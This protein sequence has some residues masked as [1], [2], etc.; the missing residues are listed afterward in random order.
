M[1][2]FSRQ[3]ELKKKQLNN[4]AFSP[5]IFYITVTWVVLSS[6]IEGVIEWVMVLASQPDDAS[7]VPKSHMLKA[8]NWSNL[9]LFPVVCI[10]TYTHVCMRTPPHVN[11]YNQNFKWDF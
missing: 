8:E 4:F 3:L 9:Y 5:S 10:C 11:K 7:S 2:S 6:S 1:S